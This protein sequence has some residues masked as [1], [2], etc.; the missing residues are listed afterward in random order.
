MSAPRPIVVEREGGKSAEGWS[1]L[2]HQGAELV[3]YPTED[4]LALG[5]SRKPGAKGFAVFL[6][7]KTLDQV[8]VKL[9]NAR[10][11]MDPVAAPAHAAEAGSPDEPARATGTGAP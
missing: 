6:D 1:F 9:I 8:I 4:G 2:D 10:Q 7:A 11:A 3:I 5:A